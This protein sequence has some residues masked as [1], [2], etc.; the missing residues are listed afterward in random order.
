MPEQL[1]AYTCNTVSDELYFIFTVREHGI[2]PFII[3][4]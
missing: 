4:Y 2:F 1:E 3:F